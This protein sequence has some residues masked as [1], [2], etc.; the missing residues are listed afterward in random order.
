MNAT[1]LRTRRLRFRSLALK[2]QFHEDSLILVTS[3]AYLTNVFPDRISDR[4]VRQPHQKK[5][6]CLVYDSKQHLIVRFHFGDL[7]NIGYPIIDITSMSTPTWSI[8]ISSQM[9][10]NY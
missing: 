7:A 2:P 6:G 4:K 3:L 1:I 9:F 8:R 5:K 10:E